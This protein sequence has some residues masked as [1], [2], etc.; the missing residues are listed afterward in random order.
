MALSAHNH[1]LLYTAP[2]ETLDMNAVHAGG[3]TIMKMLCEAG[4]TSFTEKQLASIRDKLAEASYDARKAN[5]PQDF[6]EGQ[7]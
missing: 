3:F 4:I 2:T 5:D 1:V 6:P 7:P